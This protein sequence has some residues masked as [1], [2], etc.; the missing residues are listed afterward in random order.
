MDL[1][2]LKM[3][4][5]DLLAAI[6]PGLIL[7][8]QA[9]ITIRGW[10]SFATSITS[11]SG[12]GLFVL[13]LVAFSLGQVIQELADFLIKKIKGER[14]FR[15]TRDKLWASTTGEQIR[16][17]IRTDTGHEFENVDVA[18]DYCLSQVQQTFTK[19]DL[20]LASSDLARSLVLLSI[21]GCF[22]GARIAFYISANRSM[23]WLIFGSIVAACL[24]TAS[25]CWMRMTRF[26]AL[27]ESP[28]FHAYLALPNPGT[29]AHASKTSH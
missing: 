11:I 8:F 29:A 14:F 12:S 18:F 17:R 5:Y 22:P 2:K 25:L 27:S 7:I 6:L 10:D 9:W 15:R 20:F 4:A 24:V 3:E 13:I 1:S 26:R 23:H 19:R 21:L 16:Q 28:V